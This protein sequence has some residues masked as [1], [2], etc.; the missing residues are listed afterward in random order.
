M[1]APAPLLD[2]DTSVLEPFVAAGV[3]DAAAVHV[4]GTIAR[5][6][7]G[8]DPDV[9]LGAALA[10]RAPSFGHVCIVPGAVA[11][12]I[13]LDD[14]DAV[15]L[16]SLPWPE[17][18]HWAERLAAS[19]AVRAPDGP[20]NG[21]SLPLVWDGTRLYL[22][23]YWRFERRV[24]DDLV[25]RARTAGG[26]TV[27]SAELTAILDRL[28]D[29]G[30][31]PA[32]DWQR[33]AAAV[34][35]TRRLAVIAGGPGTGKTRTIA[36]LLAAAHH[37]A[38]AG[39]HTIDVALAAP[40]GKASARMTEAVHQEV[41][42]A[43]ETGAVAEQ[44]LA[45]EAS[46]L[47]RLLGW[48]PGVEFR[49]DATSPLPHDLVVVDE[50]SMVSLPLMARLLAAVRPDATLVLVGDPYQLASVEAGAVLGEIVGPTPG[51]RDRGPLAG[52]V[53]LLE[54]VHRFDADSA[55]AALADA[56][57]TGDADR[58]VDLL[59]DDAAGEL[60]W[61]TD[62]DEAGIAAVQS[63]AAA[64]AV[65]VITA[66]RA[67]DAE[68]GLRL[69]ADR[70]VLSATRLGPLG[71]YRFG[72]RIELLASRAMPPAT[73]QGRWYVGRPI[74]VTRND[75]PNRLVNG[76]V[77]LVVAGPDRPVVAFG[78]AEG[79]RELAVSQLAEIETWWAM[80]IHKSQGSEFRQVVITLPPAPSPILTREL[81]YT[82][83]TRAK[84][85]VTVVAS[86]ASLL[87]AIAR[88]VA[89]A[90][91]LSSKISAG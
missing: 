8:L 66:A 62:D 60:T 91:G 21:V 88:P 11:E 80:T 52:R 67:G 56:V 35:L 40:T 25:R 50:T 1:K 44:L 59:R 68:S 72:D 30:N 47:H 34:A 43:G 36:R 78:A 82:A 69:A 26:I 45:T 7:G 32:P 16:D 70:K 76:D 90:S 9:L 19:G 53:V 28:F 79:I 87:A 42:A 18:E 51:E 38:L 65:D 14:P 15:A 4:A 61:I 84:E 48:T 20:V 74:I 24:A 63:D 49:H 86:E 6:V 10:A 71:T 81:L 89:R 58:A 54:R 85:R 83:V 46:T 77:G 23:R 73:M 2:R 37:L 75:Y 41:A 64:H 29:H 39:G 27:E 57:R 22:E 13:V 55:I 3:L 31:G 17:T 33:Q 12:S 5:A